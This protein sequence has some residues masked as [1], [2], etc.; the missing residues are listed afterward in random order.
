MTS[1]SCTATPCPQTFELSFEFG[2]AVWR[3]II[4]FKMATTSP[5]SSFP[6]PASLQDL[7]R[8]P[9]NLLPYPEEFADGDEAARADS[10]ESLVHSVETGNRTL[11]SGDASLFTNDEDDPWN[12][13]DRIQ[14]L[15]TLVR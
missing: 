13:Q 4:S 3:A 6:I 1:F 8:A 10:F 5:S 12:D 9:Y 11:L 15:Y 7:E 2:M 14:A